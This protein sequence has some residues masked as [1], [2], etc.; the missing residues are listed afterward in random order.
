MKPLL[1]VLK[2]AYAIYQLNKTVEMPHWT[3]RGDFLSFTKTSD[4]VS[5]VCRQKAIVLELVV[6]SELNWKIIRITGPL[7]FNLT[8]IIAGISS[9]LA[10]NKVPVFIISAFSTDYI[11]VKEARLDKAIKS[12]KQNGYSVTTE[13]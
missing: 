1:T 13:T 2:G 12:L 10:N 7:S 5:I 3:E 4:E 11:M 6:K 9:V 8:G